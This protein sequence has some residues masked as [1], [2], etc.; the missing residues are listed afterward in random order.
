VRIYVGNLSFQST[1]EGMSQL[2]SEYGKVDN[3]SI[4]TDRETG[5]SRGFGFVE[6]PEEN[7]ARAAITALDGQAWEGRNLTV[8]EARPRPPR[9]DRGDRGDRGPRW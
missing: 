6:M 5:R 2:F 7:E 9:G 4:V 3:A 8:N 1:D